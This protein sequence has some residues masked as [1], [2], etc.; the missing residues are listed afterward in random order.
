[1]ALSK[2]QT[3][4]N[5]ISGSPR[6]KQV[7]ADAQKVTDQVQ[8]QAKKLNQKINKDEAVRQYKSL[9]KKLQSKEKQLQSEVT[10]VVAKVKKTAT[11]VEKIV[12]AELKKVRSQAN[13]QFAKAKAS[14]KPPRTKKAKSSKVGKRTK[15]TAKRK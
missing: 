8:S 7:V 11:E 9:M 3:I 10:Q 15:Q 6:L 14:T 13:S 4:V 12:R 1:M 2:I 5:K